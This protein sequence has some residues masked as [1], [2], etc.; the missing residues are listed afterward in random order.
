MKQFKKLI[1]ESLKV[2]PIVDRAHKLK[3]F[4]N[5]KIKTVQLRVKDL[6]DEAL[7]HEI[8]QAV[9]LSKQYRLQLFVNDYWEKAIQ[10]KSFGVHLGQEDLEKANLELILYHDIALGISTHVNSNLNILEEITPSYIALG[11]IYKTTSKQ[12]KYDP[13]GLKM[14]S[15]WKEQIS[16]P[17]IAIGGITQQNIK[18]IF[19]AGADGVAF[20]SLLKNIDN[21][22][23]FLKQ[24]DCSNEKF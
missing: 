4:E 8:E 16:S 23:D 15:E 22:E 14:I 12:S 3:Q 11:P 10:F 6:E 18:N 20:I 1:T 5:S 7:N 21:L 17:L 2:Y 13:R 9:Y 19:D 24:I